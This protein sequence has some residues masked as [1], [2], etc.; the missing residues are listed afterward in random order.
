MNQPY[1]LLVVYQVTATCLSPLRVGAGETETV[2]RN[3]RHQAIYPATSLAGVLRR[4]WHYLP[5]ELAQGQSTLLGSQ[6]KAGSLVIADGLFQDKAKIEVRPRLRMNPVTATA[7]IG[8]KFDIAHIAKGSS[9]T[10]SLTWQGTENRREELTQIE[11]LLGLIHQG[12]MTLG[13]QKANGFG[14]VSLEM[15]KAELDLRQEEQRKAWLQENWKS[16]SCAL[17]HFDLS[18]QVKFTVIGEVEGILVKSS[19]PLEEG[20]GSYMPN[21]QEANGYVLPGSSVKGVLRNQVRKIAKAL[22]LPP[23]ETQIFGMAEGPETKAGSI[24]VEDAQLADKSEKITRIRINRFTAG[25]IRGG[26]F[27]EA[28]IASPVTLKVSLPKGNTVGCGLLLYALRDLGLG[29]CALGSGGSVG[30]GYLIT[31]TILARNWDGTEAKLVFT[32]QEDGSI[33]CH[34]QGETNLFDTWLQAVEEARE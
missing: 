10:F 1:H 31:Q 13:G 21:L 19:A 26:L 6:E 32:S 22:N 30:R 2:L 5:E 24:T 12:E 33:Q 27:R 9:F 3:G 16:V 25:V 15:E 34:S 20:E 18:Q 8:G 7:D 17:P 11:A 29:K 23:V 4:A 28:P 14:R